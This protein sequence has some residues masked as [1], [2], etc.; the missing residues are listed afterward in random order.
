[1]DVVS[2]SPECLGDA[3]WFLAT[4]DVPP[5]NGVLWWLWPAHRG[6]Q[7]CVLTLPVLTL[8]KGLGLCRLWEMEEAWVL[9]P[10]GLGVPQSSESLL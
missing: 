5:W 9:G 1:M 10:W 8:P 6:R 2:G 7:M 3:C 4:W